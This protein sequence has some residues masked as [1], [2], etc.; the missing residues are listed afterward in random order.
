MVAAKTKEEA[1]RLSGLFVQGGIHKRYLALCGGTL[2]G[3]GTISEELEIKGQLKGAKT[4]YR[5]ITLG[6][7]GSSGA[8]SLVELEPATGREHQLRR[9]LALRGFPILGDDKYGDFSLNRALK[10]TLGLRNLLLHAYSLELP[11]KG[12]ELLSL[13]TSPPQYFLDFLEKTGIKE[14]PFG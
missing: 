2:P 4:L 14:L 9:H 5:R 13:K 1:A 11:R 3:Q 6:G 10:K 8:C 12:G 7:L